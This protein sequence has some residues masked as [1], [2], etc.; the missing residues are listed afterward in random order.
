[1]AVW[2]FP[3]LRV[4]KDREIAE[5]AVRA[6][7][8]RARNPWTVVWRFIDLSAWSLL[9]L[10]ALSRFI[11]GLDLVDPAAALK[12][13]LGI[14]SVTLE[15]ALV[16]LIVGVLV[17]MPF[18]TWIPVERRCLRQWLNENGYPTC[19]KCGYNLTGNKSNRCPEC[20]HATSPRQPDHSE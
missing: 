4:L 16:V 10:S 19:L 20:G 7:R 2:L 13:I 5:G 11:P 8:H 3:E 18:W 15:L 9:G 17:L 14:D 1:M 12:S 6:A